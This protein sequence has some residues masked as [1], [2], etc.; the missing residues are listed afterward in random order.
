VDLFSNQQLTDI[1]KD[2]GYPSIGVVIGLESMGLP[3]PGESLV[4]AASLYA[5][6]TGE[7]DIVL[8]VLAAA[9]GAI[10]GDNLGYLIGRSVGFRLLRRYGRYI[11]IT[12][13]RLHIG[14]RL[15]R[16]HGGKVVFFG[17][18][19]AI[20]RTLAA[21]LAGASRMPWWRFFLANASGGFVWASV[22]GFGPWLL[23]DQ[24][25][26]LQGPAAIGFGVAAVI[27]IVGSFVVVRWQERRL[28]RSVSKRGA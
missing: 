1:L 15:F 25:K 9:M 17:R 7:M 16:K 6:A 19:V 11:L 14:Q 8:V 4:I 26:K 2:Y 23:G 13:E 10:V 21:L 5:A 24:F 28:A 20:L 27:G 18:F 3:L 22:Y 12:P